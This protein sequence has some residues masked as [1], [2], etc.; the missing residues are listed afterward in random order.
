LRYQFESEEE[1]NRIFIVAHRK[2]AP[3][4]LTCAKGEFHGFQDAGHKEGVFAR[5][6]LRKKFEAAKGIQPASEGYASLVWQEINA[7]ND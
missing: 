1:G 5:V 4:P 3:N 2:K 7:G 6:W